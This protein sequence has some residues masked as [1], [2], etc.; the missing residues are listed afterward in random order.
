MEIPQVPE[1]PKFSVEDGL[2][3]GAVDKL[4]EYTMRNQECIQKLVNI[5]IA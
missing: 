2:S 3:Q 1:P 4:N 5:V